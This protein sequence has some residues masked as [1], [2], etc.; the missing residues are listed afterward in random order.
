M[1]ECCEVTDDAVQFYNLINVFQAA[2]K[3]KL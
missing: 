1:E 2:V 3:M